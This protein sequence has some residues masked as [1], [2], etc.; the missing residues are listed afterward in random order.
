M[1]L[2]KTSSF[3]PLPLL[4]IWT[5][6]TSFALTFA[7]LYLLAR[8]GNDRTGFIFL[9]LLFLVQ[10]T[11]IIVSVSRRKLDYISFVMLNHALQYTVP[12]INHVFNVDPVDT[13]PAI[14]VQA[15]V[16]NLRCALLM[17]AVYYG[18]RHFLF[19]GFLERAR[20]EELSL[21]KRAY[22]IVTAYVIVVP[23][24][25]EYFPA[26]FLIIHLSLLSLDMILMFC[27]TIRGSEGLTTLLK[28]MALLTAFLSYL[29][30]GMMFMVAN[31]SAYLLV[32]T[33]IK[34]KYINFV[35]LGL[36]VLGAAAGQTVK[37]NFRN[38]LA[39]R[40]EMSYSERASVW[41]KLVDTE[42]FS[43]EAENDERAGSEKLSVGFQRIGD[44]SLEIVLGMTPGQ[45][46]FWN[47]ETY[48]SLPY[49]FIPRFLWEDKPSR[50]FWNKFGRLYGVISSDDYQTSV[51]VGYLAEGYMNFGYMGMY[52]IAVIMGLL[53]AFLERMSYVILR[54]H[55][56]F[57]YVA[58]LMPLAAYGNDFTSIVNSLV[59]MSCVMLMLR[60]W[61][62]K[63]AKR[64][65]YS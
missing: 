41:W 61:L 5:L 8:K 24:F 20:F 26:A 63:A 1:S 3:Q 9:F 33:L 17:I 39:A 58:Y 54:G 22:L 47:G 10:L 34:K 59:I 38:A 60:P 31:F 11:P 37:L 46:P 56:T 12:V 40:P 14:R 28:A 16:E 36:L 50:H 57:T 25:L 65:Y 30:T 2:S 29:K 18:C 19:Y 7:Y 32:V 42:Y 13:I 43:E 21:G 48:L 23:L 35:L 49:M 53:I 6:G 52:T 51:G 64:D 45:V 62:L 27:S 15:I 44:D 4:N 55:F